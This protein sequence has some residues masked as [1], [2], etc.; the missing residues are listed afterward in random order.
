MNKINDMKDGGSTIYIHIPMNDIFITLVLLSLIIG[1]GVY[2]FKTI[3]VV[4]FEPIGA[5]L[6]FI[7]LVVV[8]ISILFCIYYFDMLPL[9]SDKGEN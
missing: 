5:W 8:A 3:E 2:V 1:I 6:P 4:N 9:I 7:I